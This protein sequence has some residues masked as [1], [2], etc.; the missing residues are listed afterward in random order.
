MKLKQLVKKLAEKPN[1]DAEVYF[2]VWEQGD[3]GNIVCIDMAGP[4]T[5]DIMR[6]IGKHSKSK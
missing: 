5:T 6:V 1:Q 2:L 3:K 4:A